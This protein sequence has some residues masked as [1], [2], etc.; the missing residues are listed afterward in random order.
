MCPGDG[1]T[2]SRAVAIANDTTSGVF[3]IAAYFHAA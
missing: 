3:E 1:I 2:S